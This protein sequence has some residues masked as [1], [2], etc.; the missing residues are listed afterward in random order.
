MNF[1]CLQRPCGVRQCPARSLEAPGWQWLTMVDNV[2]IGLWRGHATVERSMQLQSGISLDE[3]RCRGNKQHFKVFQLHNVGLNRTTNNKNYQ[4]IIWEANKLMK[5]TSWG[6]M[7]WG[8]YIWWLGGTRR[9][10]GRCIAHCWLQIQINIA[11]MN[12]WMLNWI[13]YCWMV[14]NAETNQLGALLTTHC[15]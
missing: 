12:K 3:N 9:P 7:A 13:T 14:L 1:R 15:S 6:T 8:L 11:T 2:P 5:V 10:P 4:R